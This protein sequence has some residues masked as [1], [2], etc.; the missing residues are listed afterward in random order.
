M[1][2]IMGHTNFA[3]PPQVK[4]EAYLG[5]AAAAA[6]GELEV[7]VEELGLEHVGDAWARLAEGSSKK[8]VLVP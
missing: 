7:D 3:A 8:I 2:V 4:R 6:R 1:L 5:M